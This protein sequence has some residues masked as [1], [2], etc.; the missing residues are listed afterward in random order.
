MILTH[1][2]VLSVTQGHLSTYG[3]LDNM[4]TFVVK[5]PQFKMES[6]GGGSDM[7]TSS[8]VKIIARKNPEAPELKK[9]GAKD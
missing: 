7:V 4:W 1:D 5:D 6:I 3:L 9:K 2:L 8:R